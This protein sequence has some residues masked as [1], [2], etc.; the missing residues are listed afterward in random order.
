WNAV[1]VNGAAVPK[2]A[3]SEDRRPH[4][5]FGTDGRLSGADGCNRLAGPY[6]EGASSI[7]FGQ[8]IGTQM[9]CA[10][11]EQLAQRFRGALSG[12]TRWR[13]VAGRL[14]SYGTGDAPLVVFERRPPGS[15]AGAR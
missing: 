11:T 4:L 8:I 3:V 15:A 1:E 7:S 10:E 2:N 6:S 14:T 13:L 9:A 5:S 12:T